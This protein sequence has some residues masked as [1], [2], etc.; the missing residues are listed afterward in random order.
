M[1]LT[2]RLPG[3]LFF[4]IAVQLLLTP[5]A[6]AM[7]NY[8]QAHDCTPEKPYYAFCSDSIHSL[9]GWHGKCR[10]TRA[11]AQK[12]ASLH[13]KQEHGGN[14]RWTGVLKIRDSE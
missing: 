5:A 14:D 3:M 4:A 6:H 2:H 9:K 1:R 13:A 7:G 12:D 10:A 11:E 8:P